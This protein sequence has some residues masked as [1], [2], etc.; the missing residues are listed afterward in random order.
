MF[1][2]PSHRCR[3]NERD[4]P[5]PETRTS[6]CGTNRTQIEEGSEQRSVVSPEVSVELR[7][8]REIRRRFV[9]VSHDAGSHW[10]LRAPY[11]PLFCPPAHDRCRFIEITA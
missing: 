4:Q 9:S 6:A 2:K 5:G 10:P 3:A 11:Q 7:N 8:L 1:S